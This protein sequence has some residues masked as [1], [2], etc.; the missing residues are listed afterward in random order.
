MEIPI[1]YEDEHMLAVNKP[2]GLLV[3]SSGR[4]GQETLVDWLVAQ[5]PSIK[6]VGEDLKIS[7]GKT[8][9]KSG[10]VHRLDKDTS[11]V[12][13]AAKTQDAFLFLKKQ[14][15]ERS[16]KKT[17]RA[18]VYGAVKEK[19][20][21]I[22]LPIGRSIS[23]WRKR[24]AGTGRMVGNTRSAVTRYKVLD[25]NESYSYLEAYPETGRTHQIRVHLK[26]LGHPIVCDHLYAPKRECP[27]TLGRLALH[28]FAV[29]LRGLKVGALRIE[30]S[31][32]DDFG[33]GLET[34]FPGLRAE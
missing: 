4:E 21:S 19:E 34:L 11:G 32:P 8:I 29:E 30:A 15:Q 33:R 1:I 20:G 9:F 27:I 16:L 18:I 26:A 10:I 28:A 12:L 24:I 14:F 7:S 3:H 31:L 2:A 17:Y 23:D 6:T 25:A 5:Y 13:L 22:D